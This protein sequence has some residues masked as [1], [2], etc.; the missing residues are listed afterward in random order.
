MKY[1]ILDLQ[2]LNDEVIGEPF[3]VMFPD[4]FK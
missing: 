2:L 1:R 3:L 4:M